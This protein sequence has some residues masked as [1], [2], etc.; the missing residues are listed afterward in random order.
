[1]PRLLLIVFGLCFAVSAHCAGADVKLMS[2]NI[3]CGSCEQID[4]VNHWSR[5]QLLVV[6]LIKK[7]QADLIGL[8]E[9]E[10]F[11]VRDLVAALADYEFVAAGRHDGKAQGESTAILYRK[12]RFSLLAQQTLWLSP[13]PEVIGKGWDA[14]LNRTATMVRLKERDGGAQLVLINS[15]FDHQGVLARTESTRLLVKLARAQDVPV[16]VTGDFNYTKKFP[17]YAIIADALNDAERITQKPAEGG[18]ISFNGFGKW[19]E[20]GNKID[21]VFVNAGFEVL[22]HA[23]IKDTYQ[24][25]YPSD[26]YALS[27]TLRLH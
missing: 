6:D 12:S 22:T 18:D 24:G 27:A 13:T 14:A 16:V 17:A 19:I 1:M 9:A 3:R 10:L 4:D 11:Q 20:P 25:N 23:I 26:H 5:R 7:S 2:L 21:Y 15:H 8:Q